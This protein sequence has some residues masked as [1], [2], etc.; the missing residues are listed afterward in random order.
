MQ[1]DCKPVG[2]RPAASKLIAKVLRRKRREERKFEDRPL[3]SSKLC[4][5]GGAEMKTSS[6]KF[7][8]GMGGASSGG[9]ALYPWFAAQ[10]DDLMARKF[11][12]CSV[13]RDGGDSVAWNWGSKVSL[14]T[15]YNSNDYITDDSMNSDAS[16]R[17]ERKLGT[18]GGEYVLSGTGY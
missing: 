3:A 16:K 6:Q 10:C 14:V 17:G 2:E 12:A 1:G 9:I 15:A 11:V 4:A 5:T 7:V 18:N 8:G 13:D